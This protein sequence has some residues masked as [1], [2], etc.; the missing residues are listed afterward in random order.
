MGK[1]SSLIQRH[2]LFVSVASVIVAASILLIVVTQL[3]IMRDR[4]NLDFG[5]ANL[6]IRISEERYSQAAELLRRLVSSSR[7]ASDY[8]ALA[9]RSRE[10]IRAGTEAGLFSGLYETAYG[11]FP[12]NNAIRAVYLNHLLEEGRTSIAADIAEQLSGKS[13]TAL[14]VE[15]LLRAGRSVDDS[16]TAG[17]LDSARL[18]L[19]PERIA[20][21]IAM[22]EAGQLTG[23]IRYFVNGSLMLAA[24]GRQ[25]EAFDIL[26]AHRSELKNRRDALLLML[27]AYD[28]GYQGDVDEL[29]AFL[30]ASLGLRVENLGLRADLHYF[31]GNIDQSWVYHKMAIDG[32]HHDTADNYFNLLSIARGLDFSPGDTEIKTLLRQALE[33][34]PSDS[35]IIAHY[36]AYSFDGES[37]QEFYRS[38]DF[39]SARLPGNTRLKALE[40]LAEYRRRGAEGSS[41]SIERSILKLWEIFDENGNS[42]MATLL[43]Y[44][45]VLNDARNEL[46]LYLDRDDVPQDPE[47]GYYR[48]ISALLEYRREDARA[49]LSSAAEA[50]LYPAAFNLGLL[51]LSQRSIG[52][53][54]ENFRSAADLI[55]RRSGGSSAEP[56]TLFW[57][58]HKNIIVH[59]ALCHALLNQPGEAMTIIQMLK[60]QG[61][62][63][64]LIPGITEII[65]RREAS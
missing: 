53:A 22:F 35:R 50:G 24:L 45:L 47:T 7:G 31:M 6:D 25:Q 59:I 4:N 13:Y 29:A 41:F 42:H 44:F 8:L 23:D 46:F 27:L 63:H 39:Y 58:D 15:A 19:T 43:P 49:L 14:K 18:P 9:R 33:Y 55:R 34:Y 61:V 21:P 37:A 51:E 1:F 57:E 62:H 30:P 16:Q 48:G 36:L 28:T 12:G 52:D 65:A 32:Q 17:L 11:R 5:L 26:Y 64:S 2:R 56:G 20:D 60:S 40:L 3:L 54:L 10:L 38:L